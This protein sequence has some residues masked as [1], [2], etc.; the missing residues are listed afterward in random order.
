MK[1]QNIARLA[2]AAVV[3]TFLTWV[4]TAANAN[5]SGIDYYISA[6][7]VQNSHID[8]GA[9]TTYFEDFNNFSLSGSTTSANGTVT[10]ASPTVQQTEVAG[11]YGGATS[12]SSSPVVGG[13]GSKYIRPAR[14]GSEPQSITVS[15]ATPQ[16][17]LGFWWSA[18]SPSNEVTFLS[19]GQEVLTL[20]TADLRNIFGTAPS[21]SQ[22]INQA[23]AISFTDGSTTV[24]H[25]RVY[26]FGNP[27]GY[28]SLTPSQSLG[29]GVNFAY[30]EPFTYLNVFARGSFSFDQVVF[31][32]NGFEFDNLVTS[33]VAQTPNLLL[34][35]KVGSVYPEVRFLA[36]GGSG[37]MATQASSNSAPLTA[38]SFTRSGFRFLGWNTAANGSGTTYSNQATFAFLSNTTLYAQWGPNEVT[39]D[40]NGGSGA[41]A[42]QLSSAPASL[43]ANSFVR[44]GH[45]FTGWNTA[46]DG[47]GTSYSDQATF[48]FATSGTLYAQWRANQAPAPSRYEGP[49][50][51][52]REVL[53]QSSQ[54]TKV[55]VRGNKLDRIGSIQILGK[56]IAIESQDKGQLT[57]T[58]TPTAVGVFNVEFF[59]EYGKLTA[60]DAITVVA[61]T[62]VIVSP[63]T[64]S[65]T[66]AEPELE[67]FVATKRF[68]NFIGD[69][70]LL[71]S[72]D[73]SAIRTWIAGFD[74][75]QVVTC[76]GSTSGVPMIATDPS[77]ARKRAVN[78]CTAIAKQLPNARIVIKIENGKGIGQFFR[79]VQVTIQGQR[80]AQG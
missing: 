30:N 13:A 58:Y 36:N 69:R 25:P 4:P 40:A 63:E 70:S 61:P 74:G 6:P 39:F 79:A 72:R 2:S 42:S 10:W 45:E 34:H 50:V 43:S 15:F 47:S 51:E 53:V 9:A 38:N 26:Y 19:Q 46:A 68:F 31:S 80:A 60:L 32:G 52:L 21:S 3:A 24:N 12:T 56:E 49:T 35:F 28:S 71:V 64:E 29:S 67:P 7:F 48:T 66:T 62:P 73:R 17:Y 18:G 8:L 59:S 33:S 44:T 16:R 20:T 37:S 1:L 65:P 11:Q 27:R 54:P 5:G 57:F 78:A 41:M 77:L 75:V 14:T 23:D 76:L 22:A 55:V